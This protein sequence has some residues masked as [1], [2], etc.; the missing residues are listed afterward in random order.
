MTRNGMAIPEVSW[1]ITRWRTR[2]V[3]SGHLHPGMFL[4]ILT[5]E[6]WMCRTSS[7]MRR[8]SWLIRRERFLLMRDQWASN[9]SFKPVSASNTRLTIEQ[10][11]IQ[12]VRTSLDRR[13][14]MFEMRKKVVNCELSFRHWCGFIFGGR[15]ALSRKCNSYLGSNSCPQWLKT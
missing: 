4:R 3:V 2:E 14:V 1:A 10:P 7:F 6:V 8:A 13:V 5:L 9:S 15:D 11:V 12:Y